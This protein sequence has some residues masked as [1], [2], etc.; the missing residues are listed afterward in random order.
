M[1]LNSFDK[2]LEIYKLAKQ[3]LGEILSAFE[4]FDK[5]CLDLVLRHMNG[6]RAPFDSSSSQFNL[7]IETA[8]SHKEHD[9]EKLNLFLESLMDKG[10]IADGLVA[11]DESQSHAFW[12]LRESVS[13]ACQMEGGNIK[14]DISVPL[15]SFYSIVEKVQN[16]FMNKG[17]YDPS[18]P[19]TSS[20]RHI[21]G[22]GHMGD[23]NVHLNIMTNKRTF[24]LESLISE[25][26]YETTRDM[27]GSISAEHGL[28]LQKANHM[29]YSKSLESIEWMK[30]MKNLFD[31]N[32]IMNPYKFF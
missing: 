14:F 11:Q 1:T 24:E 8:G 2:V 26:V 20:I 19:T 17:L 7:L 18:S 25:F 28:G 21:V 10:L 4:C 23:G 22:F 32:G 15:K 5:T 30:K 6:V 16:H 13:D 31:P 27:N 29:H 3:D 12:K 9:E